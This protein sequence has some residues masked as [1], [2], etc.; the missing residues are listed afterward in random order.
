MK[1]RQ[2]RQSN[3]YVTK[4]ADATAE[5]RTNKEELQTELE[6]ELLGPGVGPFFRFLG[7]WVPL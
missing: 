3:A 6:V 2:G 7:F 5:A 4:Q 1:D